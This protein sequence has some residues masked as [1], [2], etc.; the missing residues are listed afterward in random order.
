MLAQNHALVAPLLIWALVLATTPAPSEAQHASLIECATPT[1]MTS[2]ML[3][4]RFR[5][6]APAS[7][8]LI[9]WS[10]LLFWLSLPLLMSFGLFG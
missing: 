9:G 6:D 3:A 8:L 2:L 4:E 5:L 1:F 7:A 10:T